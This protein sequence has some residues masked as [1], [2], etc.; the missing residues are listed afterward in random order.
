MNQGSAM[1]SKEE[2]P[3]TFAQGFEISL[4]SNGRSYARESSYLIN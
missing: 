4:G 3:G 2:A 1:M